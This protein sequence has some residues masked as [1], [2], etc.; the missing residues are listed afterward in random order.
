MTEP[1]GVADHFHERCQH[2][3]PFA[4]TMYGIPG[5]DHLLPDESEAG[6]QAWRAEAEGFVREADAID[7]GTLSPADAV[8]LDCTR[9]AAAQ[10]VAVVDLAADDHTVTA[11]HYGGPAAY[12]AVAARTVLR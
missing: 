3:H 5:Y 4:A 10:E 8:T 12:L 9:G 11:M 7:R 6:Q 2:V 1:P